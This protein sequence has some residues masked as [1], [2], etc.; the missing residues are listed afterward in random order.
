MP[1]QIGR[2]GK[3]PKY[4]IADIGGADLTSQDISTERVLNFLIRGESPSIPEQSPV[5]MVPNLNDPDTGSFAAET[6]QH[7]PSESQSSSS[8]P[9]PKSSSR[10]SLARLFERASRGDAVTGKD[11]KLDLDVHGQP[12]PIALEV[13]VERIPVTQPEPL[14]RTPDIAVLFVPPPLETVQATRPPAATNKPQ[15]RVTTPVKTQERRVSN[16]PAEKLQPADTQIS[17][18]D[19]QLISLWKTY[20]RLKDGEIQTL[21]TLHRMAREHGSTECYIK[22]HQLAAS[23]GLTYRYCQKVVRGL[24]N[25]GWITKLRDYEP[26][27]QRGVL[28]LINSKPSPASVL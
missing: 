3:K 1:E 9:S 17:S 27:D 21:G 28:Y 10:K 6:T 5:L 14:D 19:S 23:S 16:D 20:Y 26:T 7:L 18:E 15:P 25:L 22:M 2:G 12:S 11:L 24:E 13:E 4:R 8:L